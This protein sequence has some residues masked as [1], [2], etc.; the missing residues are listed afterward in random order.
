LSGSSPLTCLAWKTLPVA[1]ATAKHSSWDHVTTQ[2]S[3]LRQSRDTLRK[4]IIPKFT[5]IQPVGAELSHADDRWTYRWMDERTD[6]TEL[7]VAF[8]NNASGLKVKVKYLISAVKFGV[9]Q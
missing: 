5:K 6:M 9:F 8:H 1:Y 3:P 2:A 7:T 4:N